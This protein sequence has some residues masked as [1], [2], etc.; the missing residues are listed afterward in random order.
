MTFF[1]QP[2][3]TYQNQEFPGA[4]LPI[5]IKVFLDHTTDSN[6]RQ[7]G[8]D[9]QKCSAELCSHWSHWVFYRISVEAAFWLPVSRFSIHWHLLS[10]LRAS[11]SRLP[12][13]ST[14]DAS[15]SAKAKVDTSVAVV[16]AFLLFSLEKHICTSPLFPFVLGR[17]FQLF[18]PGI[19]TNEGQWIAIE[20]TVLLGSF[21]KHYLLQLAHPLLL[22]W[23][24]QRLICS[25]SSSSWV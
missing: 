9:L 18:V 11:F 19:G 14:H 17:V 15:L 4:P 7:Q 8:W 13:C 24:N 23:G 6:W 16:S 3:Y 12:V 25:S 21:F 22:K 1:R 20:R 10:L 2:E 5:G